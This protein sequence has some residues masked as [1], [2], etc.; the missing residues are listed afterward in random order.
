MHC[1]HG[2]IYNTTSYIAHMNQLHAQLFQ[3]RKSVIETYCQLTVRQQVRMAKKV[4]EIFGVE[5]L[6]QL[7]NVTA[8][9]ASREHEYQLESPL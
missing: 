3:A 4:K 9:E 1:M 5:E 6:Q 8:T 7:K 2:H